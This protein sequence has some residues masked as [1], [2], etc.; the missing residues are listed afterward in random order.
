LGIIGV[1]VSAVLVAFYL[2]KVIGLGVD[3]SGYMKCLAV[4][5]VST[6][7]RWYLYT[8][9]PL[10]RGVLF[11]TIAYFSFAYLHYMSGRIFVRKENG[12]L[13]YKDH[14]NAET[15]AD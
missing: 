9:L 4:W 15:A 6:N 12:L 5:I 7:F 8:P 1:F 13:P 2:N 14:L 11:L 3:S 10:L